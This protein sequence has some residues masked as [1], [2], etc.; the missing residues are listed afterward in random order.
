MKLIA[1]GHRDGVGK[2]TAAKFLASILKTEKRVE[3]VTFLSFATKLK[4]V[5]HQIYKYAGLMSGD[6]YEIEGNQYLKNIKI[7]ALDKTP[8]EIWIAL[9]NY[10]RDIYEHT[11]IDNLEH[12]CNNNRVQVGIIRDLRF[13]NEADGV[14]A[15]GGFV[16][17]VNN[18]R[19]TEGRPLNEAETPLINYSNWSG[20]ID[21][22]TTLKDF[23]QK[24]LVEVCP[25]LGF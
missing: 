18:K 23:Y 9:G 11:W 19:V 17:K 15:K 1:F 6:Y 16:F 22:E 14:L 5:A 13:P 21:N 7:P 20:E 4:E 8:R 10:C 25:K 3:N 24:I 2:D 12:Y